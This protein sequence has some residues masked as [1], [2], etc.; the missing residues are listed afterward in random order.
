MKLELVDFEYNLTLTRSSTKRPEIEGVTA[1]FRNFNALNLSSFGGELTQFMDLVV[2]RID[3]GLDR[4][5]HELRNIEEVEKFRSIFSPSACET[6]RSKYADF[7]RSV[8]GS[9][10]GGVCDFSN[11]FQ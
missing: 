3:D 10:V 8:G 6:T 5:R 4:I 2:T 11:A 7:Y 9:A 1:V